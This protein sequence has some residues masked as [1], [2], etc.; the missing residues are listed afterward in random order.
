VKVQPKTKRTAQIIPIP[1]NRPNTE[2][3]ETLEYLLQ[4]ATMGRLN[5]LAYAAFLPGGRY[6]ADAVGQA[7]TDTVRA[8]G[9]SQFLTADLISRLKVEV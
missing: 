3:I 4:E 7:N 9:A 5:G 8:I 6:L 1:L 2:T